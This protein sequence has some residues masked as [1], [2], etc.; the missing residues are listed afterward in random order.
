[1][2]Y[3]MSLPPRYVEPA[4]GFENQQL[5]QPRVTRVRIEEQANQTFVVDRLPAICW[6]TAR[7]VGQFRRSH[8]RSDGD[9]D[10]TF[11]TSEKFNVIPSPMTEE[12][13][14]D[15]PADDNDARGMVVKSVLLHQASCR[16][17]RLHDPD[18]YCLLSKA[19]SKSDR[20]K[21]WQSAAYTADEVASFRKRQVEDTP[22]TAELFYEYYME[23]IYPYR[24]S[25]MVFMWKV[26][27]CE[28]D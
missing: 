19:L 17:R 4:Q 22:S 18:G 14:T 20:K 3:A 16:A 26:L 28:L 23:A 7:D 6:Y 27:M 12:F 21:A 24:G 9:D 2:A 15:G 25:P 10:L 11:E 13:Q 5:K 1:M 8:Y